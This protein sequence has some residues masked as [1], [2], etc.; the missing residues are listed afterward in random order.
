MINVTDLSSQDYD[1]CAMTAGDKKTLKEA[2]K[3]K[4][5]D[6]IARLD[7]KNFQKEK[8][9]PLPAAACAAM[10]AEYARNKYPS[11]R[12]EFSN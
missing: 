3:A 9:A 12:A 6:S 10:K 4:Y 11:V 8:K 7:P 1:E 2:L 5:G